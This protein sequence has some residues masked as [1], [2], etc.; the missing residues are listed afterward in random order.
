MVIVKGPFVVIVV[1]LDNAVITCMSTCVQ[2]L[3][4]YPC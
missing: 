2:S 3:Y 1:D 4:D